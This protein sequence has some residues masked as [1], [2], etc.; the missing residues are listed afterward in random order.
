MKNE[1][2]SEHKEYKTYLVTDE[3]LLYRL[4]ECSL[5]DKLC[6]VAQNRFDESTRVWFFDKDPGV[7]NVIKKYK[8]EKRAADQ[9]RKGEKKNERKD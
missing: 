3:E 1:S 9:K 6:H 2:N 8:S 4:A 7:W 5:L